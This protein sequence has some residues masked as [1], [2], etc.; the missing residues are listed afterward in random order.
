[1]ST[2]I[3][4][5][6][7]LFVRVPNQKVFTSN[8]TNFVAHVAR[9]FEYVVG[10]RYSDDADKAIRIIKDLLREHPLTLLNPE[11]MAFVDSLGD[12]AVNIMVRAWA[13]TTEWFG[14]KTE[15][16]WKIKKALENQGIEIAFPQRVVWFGDRQETHPG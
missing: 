11:P 15:L 5:Y 14:V 13:P 6:D 4:Q 8:I 9:R 1:M 3:R 10:I 12:N 16:L 2:T 7:G